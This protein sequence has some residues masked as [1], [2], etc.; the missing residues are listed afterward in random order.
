MQR[1]VQRKTMASK[2]G[3]LHPTMPLLYSKVRVQQQRAE[4][5]TGNPTHDEVHAAEKEAQAAAQLAKK[6]AKRRKKKQDPF[7][8]P[9]PASTFP[10]W[11]YDKR[12]YFGYELVYKSKISNAR[13]GRIHT[14]HG[15][16]QTLHPKP[17]P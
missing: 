9:P 13:V 5:S 17:K 1:L 14:P 15:M 3:L 8:E 16:I 2:N 7:E 6:L 4:M 12:D 10:A 11:A